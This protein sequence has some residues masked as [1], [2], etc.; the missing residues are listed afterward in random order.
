MGLNGFSREYTL[1]LVEKEMVLWGVLLAIVDSL[2]NDGRDSEEVVE[3]DSVLDEAVEMTLSGDG[4][5]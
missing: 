2:D 3:L 4:T 5:L 1:T